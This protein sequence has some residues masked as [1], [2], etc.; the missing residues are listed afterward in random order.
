MRNEDMCISY[1]K[2]LKERENDIL[3]V[4]INRTS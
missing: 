2:M 1:G 4:P 3:P